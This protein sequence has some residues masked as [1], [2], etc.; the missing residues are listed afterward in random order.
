MIDEE[1]FNYLKK[2]LEE[3]AKRGAFPGASFGIITRE[4]SLFDAVGYSQL[5]PE[6]ENTDV[7]TIY[8]LASLSKVVSTTNII[9]MLI[10]QGKI[11]LHEKVSDILGDFKHKNVTIYN[12]LTHTSGLPS[13][14]NEYKKSCKTREDLI[15]KIY[16]TELEYE[17]G[18]KVLYSD[19][20]FILL[21][22]IIEKTEGK[23][24]TVFENKIAKPMGMET[25]FYNPDLSMKTRCAATEIT[26]ERGAIRGVVHDGK[27]YLL[28][29]VSGHAGLFSIVKDLGK[30]C[31]M[32]LN[33]GVYYDE[34]S[35]SSKR[36]LSSDSINLMRQLHTSGLN[37]RRGLGW[38]L[39]DKCNTMGDAA[40]EESIYHTGFSGT[41]ILIDFKRQL[42]FILLTNRIHPTRANNE[43]LNIR[44]DINNMAVKI[45]D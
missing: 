37:E 30:L 23:I 17:T 25:T 16:E 35:K 7:D 9:L 3:S 28:G 4:E 6:K 1:K 14:V 45:R 15:N 5:V 12:L 11:A 33:E 13:D 31:Q 8:D 26:E 34:K 20:G 22:M 39:K 27:G 44:R 38:Q 36:I 40:S 41:S 10:E 21:G 19:I 2:Y 32:L 43:L 42:A 29:G 18:K 24:D